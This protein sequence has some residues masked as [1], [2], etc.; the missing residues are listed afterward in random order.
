MYWIKEMQNAIGFIEDRLLEDLH[1]EDIANTASSS[2]ANFQ[3]IFSIVTGMTV[4]DYIRA[5]R[6]SLAAQELTKSEN[7][8]LD[9]AIK[10]G[11]DTAA[12]FTKAFTRFHGITPSAAKRQ[13]SDMKYFAPF[14]ISIE[15][16]GGLS[17]S[18]KLIPNV[19]EIAYDGNNAA[20]FITLL[21]A[22]L[23]SMGEEHDYAKLTA[24]SGEGNRFCWTDGTWIF[25]NEVAESIN[26]TPV[27]T[28]HRV[29]SAIG[30]NAKYITIQ[31][32]RD[33]NYMNIDRLQI[34]QDFISSI[35]NGFPVIAR[36]NMDDNDLNVFF[37]YTDDGEKIIGYKYNV[38][39]M[40]NTPPV[41]ATIPV[42]FENWE[43]KLY[44][45][46][47]LQSKS[48]A[49]D[50][51]STALATFKTISMHA[52]K[53]NEINGK[54]IGFAAWESFLHHL[55]HDDFTA[56]VHPELRD[57]F[58]I[59]CDA[60]CQIH[61]RIGAIPYYESLAEC[62]PEWR[63]ELELAIRTLRECAAYGGFLWTQGFTFDDAGFKNFGP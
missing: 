56:L 49:S 53:P 50:E 22:T 51:R 47:L 42:E 1:I 25:G 62:F 5:R 10:Y 12:S 38:N 13:K 40:K 55:E 27:E 46:I 48:E 14:S 41:D 19:P 32:D 36:L 45:Y 28:Q 33:G 20:F 26:E 2:T 29:L 34:R 44:G 31:R 17:M 30:W 23:H 35:D 4:G 24:L 60:L 8:A 61:A 15:I 16:R 3:R 54:R 6:L 37:G 39:H 52:N 9:V 18:R 57:R 63:N 11:Y 59:Y 7:K 21:K 43:N 58:I